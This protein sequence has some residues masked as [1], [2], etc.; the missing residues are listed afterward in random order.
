MNSQKKQTQICKVCFNEIHTD[1]FH[2]LIN[3]LSIC[4]RCLKNYEPKFKEF[5][6]NGIDVLSVYEY[7]DLIKEKLFVFKGCFDYELFSTFFSQYSF[8]LNLK[9]KGYNIVFI[10]SNKHSDAQRGFNH[11]VEMFNFLKLKRLDILKKVGD[12]KQANNSYRKRKEAGKHIVLS[13]RVDLTNK[14]IL[15]VDDVITTGS[16]LYAA[17]NEI[18]KL[19]PKTIKALVMSK[20]E[21]D[22]RFNKSKIDIIQ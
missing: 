13:K 2:S 11:V 1:S 7:K 3:N 12:D 6:F 8:E 21:F 14:K 10:P 16:T 17:I 20:R 5:K 9:Y 15:I 22:T 4:S 18:R 19:N